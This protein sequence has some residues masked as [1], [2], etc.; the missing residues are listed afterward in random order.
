MRFP[1]PAT[2]QHG[3]DARI[4]FRHVERLDDV[5]VGSGTQAVDALMLLVACRENDDRQGAAGL[6]QLT[7]HA[8][9]VHVGQAHV[10]QHQV[11]GLAASTRQCG[12]AGACF[13]NVIA[14]M[15][16]LPA[17][18]RGDMKVVFDYE[19]LRIHAGDFR[20]SRKAPGDPVDISMGVIHL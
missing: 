18:Q 14:P 8:R 4:E 13:P 16:Q 15:R 12:S 20:A 9:T 2:S 1:V 17:E 6:A 5:V 11:G 3:L 10:Q 7:Q 19:Y